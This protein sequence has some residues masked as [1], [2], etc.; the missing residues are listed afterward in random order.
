MDFIG[1]MVRYIRTEIPTEILDLALRDF[2]EWKKPVNLDTL[3]E[4]NIV[5][6]MILDMNLSSGIK[7][8]IPFNNW[9]VTYSNEFET[10]ME[11]RE[12]VHAGKS[13]LMV[14]EIIAGLA[15][16]AVTR[17]ALTPLEKLDRSI[18][19]KIM[20]VF[21]SNIETIGNREVYI[22]RPES[23]LVNTE[24][25]CYLTYSRDMKEINPRYYMAFGEIAI[26]KAQAWIYNKLVVKMNEGALYHGHSLEVVE[27]IISN[28]S[29]MNKEYM[30][31]MN[32]V[33]AKMLYMNDARSMRETVGLMFDM[34]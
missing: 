28:W 26:M 31:K 33:G 14:T 5:S 22:G 4:K 10:V 2:K 3:I 24:V 20:G 6:E 21:D 16:T 18:G 19:P 25:V 12:G 13:I 8:N 34:T 15:S 23:M 27:R 30:E 17:P 1:S 9:V 11:L 7:V 29:D 32:V